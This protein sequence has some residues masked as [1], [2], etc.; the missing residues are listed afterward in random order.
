MEKYILELIKNNERIIVPNLGAF[1]S[2]EDGKDGVLFNNF[3]NFNDS[4][5]VDFVAKQEN[6]DTEEALKK[7]ETYVD[8][9]KQ[10][11]EK[12]KE[13][14]M[15]QI[16][17]LT[18]NEHNIIIFEPDEA[19]AGKTTAPAESKI[20]IEKNK[21]KESSISDNK[22]EENK[23][24]VD[25]KEEPKTE[26]K[27]VST[28]KEETKKET[29]VVA[30]TKKTD[31]KEKATI[32]TAKIKTGTK[33]EKK[34]NKLLIIIIVLVLILLLLGGSGYYFFFHNKKKEAPKPK[35]EKVVK[36]KPV[37]VKKEPV[38]VEE[39]KVDNSEPHEGEP[40]IY[41]IVASFKSK[42]TAVKKVKQLINDG[43]ENAECLI[44]GNMYYVS[45]DSD[46]S[47]RKMEK[48]QEELVDNKR[49]ESWLYQIFK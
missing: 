20:N 3:L 7:I 36:P 11:I 23:V 15:S 12:D 38:V 26:T 18:K 22:K 49:I 13:Y 10:G 44:K 39:P 19:L 47:F 40:G 27:V 5:L 42:D 6:I 45:I 31:S 35:I 43:Y 1:I 21:E 2:S 14:N 17:K 46:T 32:V 33:E 30:A 48:R 37:V 29:K 28:K 25:K 41:I 9:V 16:G 8:K 4:V 34:G 24:V